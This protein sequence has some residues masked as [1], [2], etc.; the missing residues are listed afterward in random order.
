MKMI[1]HIWIWMNIFWR[2]SA[3]AKLLINDGRARERYLFF[4]FCFFMFIRAS[5]KSNPIAIRVSPKSMFL[6][7]FVLLIVSSGA[8]QLLLVVHYSRPSAFAHW[9]WLMSEST[10]SGN[11][12]FSSSSH[13]M[14]ASSQQ[15]HHVF[16]FS[17]A[18]SHTHLFVF[19]LEE[20]S[21]K[22]WLDEESKNEGYTELFFVSKAMISNLFIVNVLT[23]LVPCW[24]WVLLRWLGFR[25]LHVLFIDEPP[26]FR[27]AVALMNEAN[28]C[29]ARMDYHCIKQ[30]LWEGD[31]AHLRSLGF[32]A[33]QQ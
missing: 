26:V 3:D 22:S 23:I 15:R 11:W 8:Q 5:L 1:N 6:C 2:D 25:F 31:V 17:W 20:S 19:F 32:Q 10:D 4:D 28:L 14:H 16:T 18:S 33:N 21:C 24:P 12:L 27:S 29:L 30:Q 7:T 9:R 13:D